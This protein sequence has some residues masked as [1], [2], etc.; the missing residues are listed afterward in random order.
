[1]VIAIFGVIAAIAVP[2]LIDQMP[3]YHLDQAVHS[4]VAELRTARMQAMSEGFAVDL[5]LDAYQK[6]LTVFIDRDEDGMIDPGEEVVLDIGRYDQIEITADCVGG[7]F[8]PGGAFSCP[9]GMW[10]ITVGC[11]GA[12]EIHVYVFQTGQ[13][14]QTGEAL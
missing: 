2:S 14:Q 10:K 5:L 8:R 7:T 1:M 6:T 3:Q 9:D 11:D 12:G 13:V 4:L